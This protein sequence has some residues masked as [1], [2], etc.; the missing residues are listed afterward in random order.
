MATKIFAQKLKALREENNILQRQIAAL[1][2]I[3]TP[4]Y[5]RYERGER[6]VKEEYLSKLADYYSV[7]YNELRDIWLADKVY[8]VVAEEESAAQVLDIVA[9][10]VAKYG[11]K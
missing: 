8:S 7:D 9:E 1:L 3:D 11:V 2:E 4:L 5:S 10:N 6:P